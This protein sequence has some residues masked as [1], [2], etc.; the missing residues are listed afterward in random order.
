MADPIAL[1]PGG[2]TNK[3]DRKKGNPPG[4]P[5]NPNSGGG[6]GGGSNSARAAENR[7]VARQKASEKKAGKRFLEGAANLELQAKALRHAL[8]IDFAK[9]R[10]NNLADIGMVLAQNIAALK[11]G[12]ADRSVQLLGAASDTEKATA[13]TAEHG[14]SNVFR[15]RQDTLS[16]ILQQGA[17]ETDTMRAMLM[18]ARNWHENASE[19]NRSYFDT[20]RSINTSITD[21]NVDTKNALIETSTNAEAERDRI[22]QSFYDRRSETF[23]QLGNVKGQQAD[24]YAQAK[25]M[26]VKPKKGVEKAAEKAMERAFMDAALEAGKGYTQKA[27]PAWVTD[28]KGTEM[29]KAVQSNSNLSAAM[30]LDPVE[31]AEG[32]TLRK[33]AA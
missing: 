14:I 2:K 3:N 29:V 13:D 6:G 5:K 27:L 1:P 18:S 26:G 19:N 21:L 12:S 7:A 17:G 8:K 24:Y 28:Y 23:T 30:T 16:G 32:A 33:W 22:W 9:S 25:E 20:I 31:K 11:K 10:D 15:E 4:A